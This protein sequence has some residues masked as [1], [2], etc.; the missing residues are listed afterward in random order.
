LAALT[1]WV[2]VELIGLA[3][4]PLTARLLRFLPGRGVT[5]AKQVGL[6]LASY[7]F[8]LLGILQVAE[9]TATLAWACIA[10]LAAV[11]GAMVWRSRD[12]LA[13]QWREVRRVWLAGEMLFA[14]AYVTF[15]VFRAYNPEI[16]ATEK[17]MELAFIN[18]ILR[19][20]H[21]PP[22]DP[23]LSGFAISYYY[24]GYALTAMLTLAARASSAFTFNLT[25]VTLFALTASGAFG[26]VVELV[27]CRERQVGAPQGVSQRR[28]ICAGVLGAFIVAGMGNLEGVFELIRAH[29]GGSEALW[30]WLDVRNLGG[31]A[32]S[33]HWYPDDTW[34]WWRASRVIHDRDAAGNAVEVISEFPFFS[35]LLGDNHPHVYALPFGTLALALSLNVLRVAWLRIDD[36]G[37]RT[38]GATRRLLAGVLAGATLWDWA[39]WAVL[40][41]ALGFYN[42]W[43]LP[44]HLVIFICAAALGL[45]RR[46]ESTAG[47]LTQ[48]LTLGV[49]LGAGCILLY[50]PFYWGLRTQAGGLG[51]VTAK[52]QVQQ[53]A[54]M[55]GALLWPLFGAMAVAAFS[56]RRAANT[57]LGL[58]GV[59]FLAGLTVGA[60]LLSWWTAAVGLALSALAVYL[61]LKRGVLSGEE[62]PAGLFM[63]L[64]VLA[65]A[66]LTVAVEF[67]YLRDVFDT[68]MNTVFK[69]YYQAWLL[70]GVAAAYAL[71]CLA[72]APMHGWARVA[73]GVWLAV[74]GLLLVGGLSYSLAA[75]VSKANG[76]EGIPTL[77]GERY[78]A[79]QQP[80]AYAAMRWL[81]T[82]AKPGAV[83]VEATGGSYTEYAWVS[84]HSGIP[85]LLGW[86]GHEL[87][88]RGSYDIPGAREADVAA[89]YKTADPAELRA[90]AASYDVDYVWLGPLER[91]SYGVTAMVQLALDRAFERLYENEQV[92]IYGTGKVRPH[93]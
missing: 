36:A 16:A 58:T 73:R 4:L 85:T 66:L 64:L 32:N 52:T 83:M 48:V 1:W 91:R 55:F 65:G 90:L 20:A 44:V 60:A 34:W 37:Q 38:V 89:F 84:A 27:L 72:D 74:S 21:F 19:S 6:L 28:A 81:A 35:F 59:V 70:L 11:S 33:T 5:L 82:Q 47:W 30:R 75:G 93:E 15:C 3:A 17:P 45:W 87:Q 77:D 51:L 71:Y 25:N 69:F 42:T 43:D 18:G 31:T 50:L 46:R 2:L 54:L 23:W 40:L 57:P 62:P 41:G 92:I 88:W 61:L 76:F 56:S 29:G 53:Y 9:V 63:W 86:G 26:I 78:L 13:A 39:A 79:L 80:Q 68:R 49:I 10:A 8:W 24:G 22:Q 67:V 12:E 7:A 14:L